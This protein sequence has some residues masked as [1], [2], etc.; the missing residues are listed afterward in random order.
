MGCFTDYIT[1]SAKSPQVLPAL[2]DSVVEVLEVNRPCRPGQ[3]IFKLDNDGNYVL[4]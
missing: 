1:E 2:L 3:Y 4:L